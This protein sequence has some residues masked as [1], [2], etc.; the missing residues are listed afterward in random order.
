MCDERMAKTYAARVSG[1]R[2]RF[3]EGQLRID[4][5]GHG[6]RDA[7]NVSFGAPVPLGS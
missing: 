1:K 5:N 7:E 3:G 2:D 4:D 6:E